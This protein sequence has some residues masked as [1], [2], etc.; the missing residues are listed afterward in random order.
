LPLPV[1][2]VD[3]NVFVSALLKDSTVRK[4]L[5]GGKTPRL[6][7]PEFIK[8]ELFKHLPDFSKRLKADESELKK[9]IAGLFDAAEVGMI[10]P[11]Q[12]SAFLQRALR[13]TPDP[14]DAPY[15]ALALKFGCPIWSQD[16]ALK[17][18]GAVTV[19]STAELLPKL[20]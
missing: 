3:A 9:A 14:N 8:E 1:I 7:A 13:I 15:F 10:P 6:F 2:V 5:L 12:Y 18:Q 4:L 11:E 16:K 17:K 19:Y 20:Q